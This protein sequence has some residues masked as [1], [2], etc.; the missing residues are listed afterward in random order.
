MKLWRL[1][2]NIHR[3]VELLVIV[4]IVIGALFVLR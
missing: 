1:H 2:R 3:I 4:L